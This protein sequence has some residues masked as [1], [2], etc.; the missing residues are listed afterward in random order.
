MADHA[1]EHASDEG[2]MTRALI[3]IEVLLGEGDG[4]GRVILGR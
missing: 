4:Q 1:E 2:G 3:N